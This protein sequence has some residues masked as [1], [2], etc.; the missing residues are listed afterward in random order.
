[1]IYLLYMEHRGKKKDAIDGMK[2][3]L[4]SREHEPKIHLEARTPL[5]PEGHVEH[6]AVSWTD[7][8]IVP[9]APRSTDV[10]S[11][12]NKHVSFA[13]KF[14]IGSFVFFLAAMGGA[15]YIFFVGGN[16]ISPQNIDIQVLSPSVIDG[17][18]QTTFEII[19]NNRNQSPLQLVDISIDYPVNTRDPN[20]QSQQLS[21]ER[22][23]VGGIAG[24]E[25]IK[26]TA[27]AVFYGQ[28]GSQQKVIVTLQYSVPNSNSI[29]QKKAEADFTVG[30]SPVSVNVQA[31]NEAISDQPFDLDVTVTSNSQAPIKNLVLEGQFP[32]GFSVVNATP[33]LDS[34]GNIWRLGTLAPGQARNIHLTGKIVGQDGDE[35][36]FRFLSGSDADQSNTSI[37]VPFIVVPQTLTVHKAFITATL[38]LDGKTGKTVAIQAGHAV[39]G[40]VLW[41]N[42]LTVPVSNIEIVMSLSG[43]ML[44]KNSISSTNG[45]YQS[46]NNTITWSR[47][48]DTSLATVPPGG[49]GTFPFSFNTISPGANG[50][51]YTNPTVNLNLTVSGVREGQSGVPETVSSAATIQASVASAVLLKETALHFTGPFQNS[52]P[53][54][55]VA[56]QRTTYSVVWTVQ[57]SSNTI[58][59]SVVS[60]VLP[61]YVQFIAAQDGS[62]TFDKASRTVSWAMNDLKA[63]TG[64]SMPPRSTAFQVSLLPSISQVGQSPQLTGNAKLTGQ[65]R[66]AQV[67][68]DTTAQP[69]S[70]ALV[71]DVGFQ[72]SMSNVAPKK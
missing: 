56:E 62:V 59:N 58:A 23:S 64:F 54:P 61:P 39:S 40:S 14:F 18:K 52:G 28:E 31:P 48:Q 30:S 7:S 43:P 49:T 47:D 71:G 60:A 22:Q 13:T 51:I 16:T 1:M 8:K 26:R 27:N 17:G 11:A 45:F 66:F 50:T 21:H 25:Q 33:S 70:T 69:A 35:R 19:V 4:Y 5:G 24:G 36:V 38:S 3:S 42:N 65:D 10:G 41:Q 53:M 34:G 29:F 46:Q 72:D 44:D 12:G 57:N 15:A 37:K 63:G 68:I 67:V 32:F 20:D 9:T 6:P 2:D 55:P